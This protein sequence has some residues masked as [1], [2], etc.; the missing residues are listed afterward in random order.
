MT[1]CWVVSCDFDLGGPWAGVNDLFSQ[2]LPE[3][4]IKRPD[5]LARHSFE[6]VHVCP[7][8]RHSLTVTNPTLTDVAED[9]EKV[10]NY[11]ADR[12]FRIVHGLI[13]LLD[14]WKTSYDCGTEWI[15][16][17]DAFDLG[18]PLSQYFFKELIRRRSKKL[19][20]RLIAAVKQG[21]IASSFGAVAVER[22]LG[23]DLAEEG[24]AEIAPEEVA[25]LANEL[26]ERV[27]DD[28]IEMQVHLPEL[29]RLWKLAGIPERL[30]RWKYFGLAFYSK[31]GLYADSLRYGEGLLEMAAK[32]EPDNSR[33]RWWIIIKLLNAQTGVMDIDNAIA[34]SEAALK[35]TEHVPLAWGIHLY[36]M[37][38]MLHARYKTPRD[39]AKG[40]ELLNLGLDVIFKADIS[41]EERHFRAVFNRNGVAMIRS[42]QGRFQEA[43]E[44]CQRGFNELDTHLS[45]D[46]HRLHRS[47]LLYNIAQVYV[48]TNSHVDAIKYFTAAMEMDPNY[49]EYYNERGSVFLQMGELEKAYEDYLK[50]IDLS[51]PYFE[52]FTNLGQCC[53]R[54]GKMQEAIEAYSRAIDLEPSQSLAFIGRAKAYEEL[55]HAEAAIGD[56]TG[57]LSH[58]GSLWDAFASRAVLHYEKRDLSASLSDLDSAISLNPGM[59]DLLRNRSVVLVDLGR[60]QDAARDLQSAL[61]LSPSQADR[62]ALQEMLESALTSETKEQSLA[63]RA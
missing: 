61:M 29:I 63:G 27:G 23:P 10:R 7:Q 37:A 54:M 42:F 30:F 59:P 35:E 41:E 38:A 45:V 46:R 34:L 49:S 3:I 50:A 5:L 22:L 25:K 15:I 28:R 2:L 6:L 20:I 44:L 17:C 39:L 55:G 47:I 1:R 19:A 13:D 57:A 60:R 8:L 40:E 11:A 12:A 36:Y 53:R 56:Y 48:A 4:E 62:L 16:A 21:A 31:L 9:D 18:G 14:S 26:V 32:Y 43:L 58:D 51:P 33:L 24:Q 52:V